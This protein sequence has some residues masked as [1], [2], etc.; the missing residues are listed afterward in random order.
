[1]NNNCINT[2][3]GSA[4]NKKT[5]NEKEYLIK[6]L[7]IEEVAPTMVSFTLE[8]EEE[9]HYFTKKWMFYSETLEDET[10]VTIAEIN[11][12]ENTATICIE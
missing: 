2:M 8:Y 7:E 4:D 1:M 12:N 10:I 3:M 6:F 11:V 9:S 5:I